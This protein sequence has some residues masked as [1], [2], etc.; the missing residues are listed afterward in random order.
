MPFTSY[1]I[2]VTTNR[3]ASLYVES[4]PSCLT[5]NLEPVI[6]GDI[7]FDG[8]VDYYDL[9]LFSL[10]WLSEQN[11]PNYNSDADLNFDGRI[12]YQDLDMFGRNW[13]G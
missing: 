13:E 8:T 2:N 1:Y 6:L 5:V 11:D 3:S 7:N 4:E 9:Y 10:A 12:D